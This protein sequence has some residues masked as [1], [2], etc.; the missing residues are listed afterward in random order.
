VNGGCGETGVGSGAGQPV[1]TLTPAFATHSSISTVLGRAYTPVLAM[2]AAEIAV[3]RSDFF[4]S[5]LP[6]PLIGRAVA[7]FLK[8]A[9][10]H[11]V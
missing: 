10:G 8:C 1:T 7:Y 9:T 5:G 6:Y 3:A 11:L 2:A 4:I